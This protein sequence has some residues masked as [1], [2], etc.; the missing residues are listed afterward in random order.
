LKN[1]FHLGGHCLSSES[2]QLFKV[3]DSGRILTD[4]V[5][6][7]KGQSFQFCALNKTC[8]NHGAVK[9]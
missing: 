6:D 5:M 7:F 9:N 2:D 8:Q 1:T 3:P 4:M